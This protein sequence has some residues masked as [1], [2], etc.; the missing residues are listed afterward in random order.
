MRCRRSVLVAFG[1]AVACFDRLKTSDTEE[2]AKQYFTE[3][4]LNHA[5]TSLYPSQQ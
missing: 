1:T 3:V 2:A 5:Q 4:Q